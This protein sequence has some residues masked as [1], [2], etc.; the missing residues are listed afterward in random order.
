MRFESKAA[1]ALGILLPVL[2]T[3]RRGFGHWRVEFT[4]MFEDYLAGGLLLLAAWA[5]ARRWPSQ[6][7]LMLIAWAWVTSMMTISM[8]DQVE[9]TLRGVDLAPRN[10][11]VLFAKG[12]LFATSLAALI[13]SVRQVRLSP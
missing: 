11:D 2:E 1:L 9:V 10:N 3:Y 4:T 6:A 12:V 7:A 13:R 8:V 5:A